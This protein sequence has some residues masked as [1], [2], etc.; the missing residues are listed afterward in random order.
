MK[1]VA[2][3]LM[4]R[5]ALICFVAFSSH[6]QTLPSEYSALKTDKDRMLFLEHAIHDSLDEG[7]LRPVLAWS[8]LGL[9]LAMKNDVD[10][11]KGIFLFDIGKAFTYGIG[12]F[13]SA[14]IYYKQLP[15]Y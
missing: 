6:G 1:M 15:R 3:F 13:D 5:F 2:R 12:N 10:T 7:Q 11:L 4:A 14:I 9:G 8:R